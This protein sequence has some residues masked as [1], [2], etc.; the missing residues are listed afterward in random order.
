MQ[1]ILFIYVNFNIWLS[2]C[3]TSHLFS[4]KKS[5]FETFFSPL[6]RD[7]SFSASQFDRDVSGDNRLAKKMKTQLIIV[8]MTIFNFFNCESK[9]LKRSDNILDLISGAG[10]VGEAHRVITDDGYL[11][12]VHRVLANPVETRTLRKPAFLMHGILATAADFLV[13]GPD[14][15]LAYLLADNGFDVWIGTCILFAG[16]TS[17]FQAEFCPTFARTKTLK[18]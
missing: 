5:L 9:K 6:V 11:L 8:L 18:T 10:Y 3:S 1:T 2:M 13:T 17:R 16:E 15:A 12:K 4:W 7:E 14:I